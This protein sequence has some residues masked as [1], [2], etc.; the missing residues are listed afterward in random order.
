MLK[1]KMAK[2]LR[3][4]L[5]GVALAAATLLALPMAANQAY[6]AAPPEKR[7]FFGTVVSVEADLIQVSL[8]D[9]AIVDVIVTEETTIRLPLKEDAQLTDLFEGDTLAVSMTDDLASASKI[10]VIPGKTQFRHVPGEITSVADE[11]VTLQPLAIGSEPI[12]FNI[13][14]D[15]KVNFRAGA[16]E[17]VEGVFAVVLTRR[18]I[19]TGELSRNA[20][21]IHVAAGRSRS[22]PARIGPED[23]ETRPEPRNEAEITGVFEGLDD[24]GNW[25]VSGQTVI[26]DANTEIRSGI[27]VGQVVRVEG[28]L[29]D[30]GTLLAS[31]IEARGKSR[32]GYNRARIEGI[33]DGVDGDGNWLVGGT[34]VVITDET[35]TDGRPFVGQR[36]VVV[37]IVKDQNTIIAREIENIVARQA[38]DASERHRSDVKLEGI[39][40]GVNDD[41]DWIVNGVEISVDRLTRLEGTPE[42]GSAVEIRGVLRNGRIVAL[43]IKFENENENIRE[44]HQYRVKLRG[45]VDAMS[46]DGSVFS[47]AGHRVHIS[48][49]TE[50]DGEVVVGAGVKVLAIILDDGTL[51]AK[52]IDVRERDDDMDDE[53]EDEDDDDAIRIDGDIEQVN[54]DGTF[55][56][57]GI[58]IV[59]PPLLAE[60]RTFIE[61]MKVRVFGVFQDDGSLL[62]GR[63]RGGEA[64]DDD[65][66]ED[67]DERIRG[68]IQ[69]VITEGDAVIAIVVDGRR[70]HIVALTE[71]DSPLRP[72]VQVKVDVITTDRGL[73]A[74]EIDQDRRGRRDGT[75]NDEARD[76]RGSDRPTEGDER[77]DEREARLRELKGVVTG[78]SDRR[79]VLR[80]GRTVAINADTRI[81]GELYVGAEVEIKLV[82]NEFG[83]LVARRIEVS[84]A[85]DEE[86]TD[87]EAE[88]EDLTDENKSDDRRDEKVKFDGIVREFSS[89]RLFLRGGRSLVI[90]RDTEID[91]RLYEGAEVEVKAVRRSNGTLVAV[92][93]EVEEPRVDR[94]RAEDEEDEDDDRSDNS[95]SGSSRDDDDDDDDGY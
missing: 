14:P 45:L 60:N 26:T 29:Q 13:G 12:V 70:I 23:A 20:L 43:R 89:T 28:A 65:D 25:I 11:S 48:E 39:F 92:V 35:D 79:V 8:A 10:F 58:T 41:G 44:R 52:E 91:G 53:D 56:V 2:S 7:D 76:R 83:L 64:G 75:V 80:G 3:L 69:E 95:G 37:G 27:V 61:G 46:D 34:I 4:A 15:T 74:R 51:V 57:N 18:N 59:V 54:D 21:E 38:N 73:V 9:G 78:F 88:D 82:I 49:L 55:V 17:L 32:Q 71:I 86:D 77:E 16:T 36:V 40:Q 72:G 30:D 1:Q 66:D 24:E 31:E 81:D 84:D 62:A 5:M 94:S 90:N 85:D 33:F 22:I 68:L 87:E 6:A 42:V 93:I 19:V 63:I 67:E 47:V 50:I